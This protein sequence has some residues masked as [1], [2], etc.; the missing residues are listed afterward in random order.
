MKA[1]R[2]AVVVAAA[3]LFAGFLGE[4]GTW[5]YH[6]LGVRDLVDAITTGLR[7]EPPSTLNPS[8]D[9]L[10]PPPAHVFE[11]DPQVPNRVFA[12]GWVSDEGGRQWRPLVGQDSRLVTLLG[13][14][15][16]IPIAVGP[17]G[18]VLCA[19]VLFES[20]GVAAGR[21]EVATLVEWTGVGWSVL[22]QGDDWLTP[23]VDWNQDARGPVSALA[24]SQDGTPAYVARGRLFAP[25]GPVSVPGFLGAVRSAADGSLVAVTEGAD[26]QQLIRS[27]DGG[28]SWQTLLEDSGLIDVDEGQ[29]GILHLAGRRLGRF[30]GGSWFWTD[31]PSGFEPER[32]A[33]HPRT[34]VVV[35][36]GHGRIAV[37][38]DGG[39]TIPPVS[40]RPVQ[41][42]WVA[43]DPFAPQTLLLHD[44]SGPLYRATF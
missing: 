7:V 5:Y 25:S 1:L 34:R 38:L 42:T 26:R 22:V 32:I 4:L 21:G 41:V 11:F 28:A 13:G 14:R 29:A 6:G 35:A 31:W 2:I 3:L 44:R 17:G 16:E 30:S 40:M 43:I 37:S 15:R 24:Y 36:W 33:A 8:L 20:P 23:W 10:G 12:G 9:P 18:R 39:I 27:N 19:A